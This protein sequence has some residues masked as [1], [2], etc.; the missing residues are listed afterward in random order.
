MFVAERLYGRSR[1][2]PRHQPRRMFKVKYFEKSDPKFVVALSHE[3][4]SAMFVPGE[5][6][7]WNNCLTSVKTGKRTLGRVWDLHTHAN[8]APS[9]QALHRGRAV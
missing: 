1:D 5:V 7:P 4:R 2:V 3:V 8:T 6:V 9:E